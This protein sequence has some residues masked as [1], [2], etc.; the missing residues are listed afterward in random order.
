MINPFLY[1]VPSLDVHGCD[2]TI[3][4]VLLKEF[5]D[6]Y[7]SRTAHKKLI[8]VHGKGMGILKKATYEYLKH[9]KR[10]LSFMVDFY[11]DGQTIIVLK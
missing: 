1:N 8:L 4:V 10:V 11:N 2:R 9:D 5:I 3:A 7:S 6:L